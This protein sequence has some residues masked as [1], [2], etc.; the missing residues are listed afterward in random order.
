MGSVAFEPPPPPPVLL[1]LL[2]PLPLDD[3]D[4]FFPL[5]LFLEITTPTV[6]PMAMRMI[7][8]T[9]DPITLERFKNRSKL[10]G[11]N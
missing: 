8:P 5:L 1:E 9:M 6:T 3:N 7:I 11:L 10:R 4:D 2:L